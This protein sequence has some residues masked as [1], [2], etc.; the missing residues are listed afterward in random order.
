MLPA[1]PVTSFVSTCE[2]GLK[3]FDYEKKY[4]DKNIILAIYAD[5]NE[6]DIGVS[7]VPIELHRDS[8]LKY[9]NLT[10]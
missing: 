1:L 9:S 7:T 5:C 3:N 2:L 8:F 4:L 10:G 6:S